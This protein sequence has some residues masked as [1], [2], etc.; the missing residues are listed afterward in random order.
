ARNQ[1]R[2]AEVAVDAYH[3]PAG[4]FG[5]RGIIGRAERKGPVGVAGVAY[6]HALTNPEVPGG[7][8]GARLTHAHRCAEAPPAV[9]VGGEP[10]SAEADF[11]QPAREMRFAESALGHPAYAPVRPAGYPDADPDLA[12]G[13]GGLRQQH[14]DFRVAVLGFK[15]RAR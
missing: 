15:A 11:D 10:A 3:A 8:G 2:R 5:Q 1:L 6:V 12:P 4:P 14:I 13:I 9:V 7:S